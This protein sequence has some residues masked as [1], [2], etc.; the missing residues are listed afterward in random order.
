MGALV[1]GSLADLLGHH[2][3]L[4]VTGVAV[5][6]SLAAVTFSPVRRFTVLPHENDDPSPA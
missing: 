6:F 5:F 2:S 1:G 3:A 4:L